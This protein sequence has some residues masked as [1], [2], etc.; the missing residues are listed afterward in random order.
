MC[1]QNNRKRH[2]FSSSCLLIGIHFVLITI[3]LKYFTLVH[4][5]L[6]VNV[7][8][9]WA[10][11]TQTLITNICKLCSVALPIHLARTTYV[12]HFW[13]SNNKNATNISKP[14]IFKNAFIEFQWFFSQH[15]VFLHLL[16]ILTKSGLLAQWTWCMIC[17]IVDDIRFYLHV[18][19]NINFYYYSGLYILAIP[20]KNKQETSLFSILHYIIFK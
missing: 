10:A 1:N 5:A 6:S 12:Y 7:D 4:V 18:V 11:W 14:S 2:V 3:N 17:I 19:L 9:S 8:V 16:F 13:K 20:K 15:C